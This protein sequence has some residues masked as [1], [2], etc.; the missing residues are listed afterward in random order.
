[1]RFHSG[2]RDVIAHCEDC[3]WQSNAKNAQ[4]NA[5][6]HHDAHGH[7]VSVEISQ[8]ICYQTRERYDASRGKS[9]GQR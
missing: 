5:A 9:D 4:G 8:H 7:S 2:F 3:G 1:M 6:R